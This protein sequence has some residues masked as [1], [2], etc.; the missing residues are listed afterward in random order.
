[1]NELALHQFVSW[2]IL[3][4]GKPEY[5]FKAIAADGGQV[6]GFSILRYFEYGRGGVPLVVIAS[7]TIQIQVTIGN[8]L[9]DVIPNSGAFLVG[10][11]H[12]YKL[13]L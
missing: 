12:G 13:I 3:A 9:A 6:G 1:M 11:L 7:N 8:A 2:N 4:D 5:D 10:L